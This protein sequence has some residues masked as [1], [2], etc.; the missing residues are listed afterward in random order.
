ME[1]LKG[2]SIKK[3]F[4]KIDRMNRG[5]IDVSSLREFLVAS[6]PLLQ[7]RKKSWL[8]RGL[9]GLMR[10]IAENT[11]GKI[12][13]SEFASLLKPIDLRPYLKRIRKY[14]KEEKKQVEQY[15]VTHFQKRCHDTRHGLRKPL[16]AFISSKIML[17]KDPER[18]VGLMPAKFGIKNDSQVVKEISPRF[19]LIEQEASELR[20]P[21]SMN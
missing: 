1:N 7:E 4:K 10:R 8:K 20:Q 16:T 5:Y 11:D 6:D 15:R 19:S 17:D 13:F 21:K 18:H 2:F 9:T 14:T 3:L 12:T